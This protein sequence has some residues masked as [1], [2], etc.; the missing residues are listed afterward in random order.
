[1]IGAVEGETIAMP[2][3]VSLDMP[4]HGRLDF[5]PSNRK[6]LIHVSGA[7]DGYRLVPLSRIGAY[8]INTL[9]GGQYD[10]RGDAIGGGFVSL[11]F[12]LRNDA[13]PEEIRNLNLAVLSEQVQRAVREV[14]VPAPFSKLDGDEKLLELLCDDADGNTLT[15][16]PGAEARLPFVSRA[17]CRLVIYR[18]R[19]DPSYGAQ[20][21]TVVMDTKTS[22]GGG[23][24][25]ASLNE[26]VILRPG[27]QRRTIWL[28]GTFS[29]STK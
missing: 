13:L 12:G 18:D 16:K 11:Q 24:S 23:R 26:R 8:D 15:I 7:P 28:P 9:E 10:V 4:E 1:M 14:S 19:L 17:S 27:G 3:R 25:S 29:S 20:E 21:V 22:K 6:A 2:R 5:I